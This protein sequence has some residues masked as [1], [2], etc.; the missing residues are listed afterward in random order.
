MIAVSEPKVY[1]IQQV[2]DQLGISRQHASRLI[3]D[4]QIPGALRLG[5]RTL[6]RKATFDAWLSGSDRSA[7][8]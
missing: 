2:A 4:G 8:R 1:G 7:Q 6:I 3:R 5:T